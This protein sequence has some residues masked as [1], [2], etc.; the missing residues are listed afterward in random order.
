MLGPALRAIKATSPCAEI[1]VLAS[2]GGARAARLLPWVDDAMVMRAVWQDTKAKMPL[3]PEREPD[4]VERLRAGRF[5]GAFIFTSFSQT[6]YPAASLCYLARIPLRA[7]ESREFGGGMLTLELRSLPDEMHQVDRNLALVE[8]AG[9]RGRPDLE[10]SVPEWPERSKRLLQAYGVEPGEPF[11]LVHPGASAEARR[12]PAEAYGRVAQLLERCMPVLVTGVPREASAMAELAAIAPA[13]RLAPIDLSIVDYAALI[14]AA[15]VVICNNSLPLHLADALG[16]PIV[17]LYSGTDLE[18]Q[19]R[20]RRVPHRLLRRA[21]FCHPCYRF[22]CPIGKPCLEID[23]EEVVTA[24]ED[25]LNARTTRTESVAEPRQREAAVP[26]NADRSPRIAVLRAL[27]LGDMLLAVPAL[28]ALR[29]RYPRAQITLI[30]LPWCRA[31][32]DRFDAYIDRFLEFPGY[33]G[34]VEAP[35]QPVVAENFLAREAAHQ[36]DLAIQMH[37]SGQHSNGFVAALHAARTVGFHTPDGQT[38]LH[39]SAPYPHDQ[40]EVMRNLSLVALLGADANDARLEFPV[41]P[42]DR[43]EMEALLRGYERGRHLVVMHPGARSLSRRWPTGRFAEVGLQLI[44]TVGAQV[45]LTGSADETDLS[46]GVADRMLG[47][48]LNLTGR[49]SLGGLAAL[50]ERAD[51]FIGNDSGPGHLAEAVATSAV[52]LYGPEDPA[53]WGPLDR[54]GVRLLRRRARSGQWRIDAIDT[55][56]V[57]DA[58]MELLGREP[59]AAPSMVAMGR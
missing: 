15:S 29:R 6:P 50:L 47:R 43:A 48:T 46:R 36:Y 40:P 8:A 17:A 16:T 9:F 42:D 22:E 28:R 59:A 4:Y 26:I 39:L 30:G 32:A 20:P 57:V 18:S 52:L 31:F 58:A 41:T 34:I 37:G 53:R 19:W 7:G 51:L 44:E 54:Q 56:D 21:T 1:T 45:V 33:P 49:T 14:A 5:D 13:A 55:Q 24:V 2:P 38:R 3:D 23:P 35:F 10:V 25:V 27:N 11:A 12:Y